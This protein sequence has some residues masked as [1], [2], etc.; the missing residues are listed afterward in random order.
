[1]TN[2]TN[3]EQLPPCCV[4]CGQ[5]LIVLP[6]GN[7]YCGYLLANPP[8]YEEWKT[9]SCLLAQA[10]VQL[11]VETWVAIN[12]ATSRRAGVGEA[13]DVDR[14]RF[15]LTQAQ[16][17]ATGCE[18]LADDLKLARV[19]DIATATSA[20]TRLAPHSA[21]VEGEQ[22]CVKCGHAANDKRRR[23]SDEYNSFC[24]YGCGCDCDFS[25]PAG[26]PFCYFG[27]IQQGLAMAG[28]PCELHARPALPQECLCGT[29]TDAGGCPNGH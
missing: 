17:D 11:S 8:S 1:M 7:A 25:R 15:A 19:E 20:L 4:L 12:E 22:R 21:P 6:N 23:G 9:K 26:C 18:C 27:A 14:I 13:Q 3:Q 10:A 29:D 5:R 24:I 2:P 16:E 28:E